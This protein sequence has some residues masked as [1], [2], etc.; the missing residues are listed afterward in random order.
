MGE[1]KG[2]RRQPSSYPRTN[3][4][5]LAK[6]TFGRLK[7]VKET[8]SRSCNG[9]IVWQ[10]ACRCGGTALV[11]TSNL[12]TGNTRSCGCYQADRTR[13]ATRDRKGRK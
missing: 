7:V 5:A 2:W 6:R 8:D 9:Q 4:L 13:Q 1:Q 3:A 12:T 11:M 10:C